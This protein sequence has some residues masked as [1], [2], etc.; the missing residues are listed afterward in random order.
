MSALKEQFD[1]L[2]KE[3]KK[4]FIPY[5]PFGFPTLPASRK[6]IRIL[7]E[8]GVTAIELGMPFSDPVADGPIIQAASKK[9]LAGGVTLPMLLEH[10]A[11]LKKR[12]ATPVVLMTYY[13]PVYQY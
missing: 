8:C 2:A 11:E 12:I 9:A 5:V 13:N 6:I 4:A 10:V 7:A 1:R 3:G